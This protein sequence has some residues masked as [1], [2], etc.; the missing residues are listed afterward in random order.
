MTLTLPVLGGSGL[1]ADRFPGLA[2]AVLFVKILQKLGCLF[3]AHLAHGHRLFLGFLTTVIRG[4]TLTI[5][6]IFFRL[7]RLLFWL[8]AST[9]VT[10]GTVAFG[11]ATLAATGLTVLTI[12]LVLILVFTARRTLTIVLVL[13]LVLILVLV[14]VVILVLVVLLILVLLLVLGFVN[15]V[16]EHLQLLIVGVILQAFVTGNLCRR[17]AIFDILEGRIAIVSAR[18]LWGCKSYRCKECNCN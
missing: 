5:A 3:G 10:V 18:R 11:T 2:F 8:F 13:I 15:T 17:Q 7:F 9:A 4:I 14:L 6:R 1:A 12:L 16:Q